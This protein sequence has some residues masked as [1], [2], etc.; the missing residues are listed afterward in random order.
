MSF[1]KSKQD[2]SSEEDS[3]NDQD[4]SLNWKCCY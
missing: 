1:Y 4:I 3:D 2:Q